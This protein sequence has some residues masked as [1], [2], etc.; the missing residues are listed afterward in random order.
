MESSE[1]RVGS[2]FERV[3]WGP[4]LLKTGKARCFSTGAGMA[5]SRNA[6]SPW[7]RMRQ[8]IAVE[9]WVFGPQDLFKLQLLG[10]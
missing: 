5:K 1:P 4:S 10:L 6:D 3:G 8:E 9:N 7:E 2:S